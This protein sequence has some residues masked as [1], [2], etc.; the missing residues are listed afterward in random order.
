MTEEVVTEMETL[1][2]RSE[3]GGRS[4]VMK[5]SGEKHPGRSFRKCKRPNSRDELK[6]GA[7]VL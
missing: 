6:W 3:R 4:Q 7:G 5:V 1:Q 2:S